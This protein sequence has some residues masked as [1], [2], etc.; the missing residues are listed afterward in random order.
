MMNEMPYVIAAYAITWV[1]LVGYGLY[2]WRG[3]TAAVSRG[4][5]R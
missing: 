1:V 2:L 3:S 5:E 4:T